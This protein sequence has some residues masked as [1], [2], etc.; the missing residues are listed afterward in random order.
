MNEFLHFMMTVNFS[1]LYA[2]I[3]DSIMNVNLIH[4][5]ILKK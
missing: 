5:I 2:I 1:I 4:T 3:I